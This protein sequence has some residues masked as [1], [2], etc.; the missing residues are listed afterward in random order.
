MTGSRV[1]LLGL[2]AM[3]LPM[4]NCLARKGFEVTAWSRREPVPGTLSSS[5]AWQADVAVAVS[6]ADIVLIMV[7]DAA[8]VDAV[9]FDSGAASAC[10]AGAIVVDMGTTGIDC[11]IST[12]ARLADMNLRYA[13]APVS[14]GILGAE[15]GT[16][17]I[18]VGTSAET[19]EF[20]S[21]VL[22]GMGRPHHLGPI[23]AGQAAKLANQM[24]V[25]VTIAAVSEGIRFAEHAGIDP[26]DFITAVSGGFADGRVMQVHGRRMA[27]RDFSAGGATRLHLKDLCLANEVVDLASQFPHASIVAAVFSTMHAAGRGDMDHSAYIM[28]SAQRC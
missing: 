25:A 22:S 20:V 19:F 8:A 1:A 21:P 14:G 5:I 27:A 4:A 28:E 12:A 17:S 10:K 15:A 9:L 16:L 11:A 7:T 26:S 13:D 2:G 3:G 24:V 23:G 18:F 6:E